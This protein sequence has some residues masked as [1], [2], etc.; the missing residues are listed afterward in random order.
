M[1]CIQRPKL[2]DKFQFKM[3]AFRFDTRMAAWDRELTPS[4]RNTAVRQCLIHPSIPVAVLGWSRGA[5]APQVS[6]LNPQFSMGQ[7]L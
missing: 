5:I 2:L 7:I 3:S 1:F 6:A 4:A